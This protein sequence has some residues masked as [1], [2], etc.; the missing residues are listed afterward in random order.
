LATTAEASFQE[1][2]NC[3]QSVFAAHAEA[4]GVNQELAFRIASGLGAGMGR[5]QETCGAVT[6]ACLVLGLRYGHSA[7]ADTEGKDRVYALVQDF[8]RRFAELH[9]TTRCRD[10]LGCDIR[11]EPGRRKFA[12][13]GLSKTVCLPCV[14]SADR[15]LGE[16]VSEKFWS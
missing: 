1:G 2:F 6:G 5:M 13:E 11:T 15:I 8:H 16:I 4:L 10:L 9:G 12:D 14:R 7:A 3:S